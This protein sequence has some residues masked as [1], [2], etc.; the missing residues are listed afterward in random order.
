ML[1]YKQLT[2]LSNEL[3]DSPACL[4]IKMFHD[5]TETAPEFFKSFMKICFSQ[6]LWT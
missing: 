6:T 3:T 5:L 4:L 2:F 1:T